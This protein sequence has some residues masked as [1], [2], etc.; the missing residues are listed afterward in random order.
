MYYYVSLLSAILCKNVKKRRQT[1][2]GMKIHKHALMLNYFDAL[3]NYKKRIE[4]KSYYC[5]FLEPF[6]EYLTIN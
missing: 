3:G 1:N 2:E 4:S 6:Y 5:Y